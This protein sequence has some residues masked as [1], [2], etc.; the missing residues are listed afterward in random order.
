MI[1][2]H[3]YL[4]GM[5][6]LLVVLSLIVPTAA[7]LLEYISDVGIFAISRSTAVVIM[8]SY[9]LYLVFQLYTDPDFF[10]IAAEAVKPRPQ[11]RRMV[12]VPGEAMRGIAFMGAKMA[13]NSGGEVNAENIV[14]QLEEPTRKLLTAPVAVGP[15]A[16]A[17]TLIALNT[18]FTTNSIKPL[19]SSTP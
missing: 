6:L 19:W 7:R 4:I 1:D 18:K 10:E 12:M 15:V 8:F 2:V 9:V 3:S 16:L 17:T 11:I 5:L 13:A 14:R